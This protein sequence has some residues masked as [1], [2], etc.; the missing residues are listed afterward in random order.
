MSRKT[1]GPRPIHGNPMKSF[2][3]RIPP[4]AVERALTLTGA[5]TPSE[6]IRLA[7]LRLERQDPC[8]EDK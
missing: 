7:V 3:V 4:E 5:E 6:A 2:S 1:P 8:H